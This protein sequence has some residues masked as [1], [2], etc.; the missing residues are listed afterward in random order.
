MDEPRRSGD[1]DDPSATRM[2]GIA[3]DVLRSF[4][5]GFGGRHLAIIGGLVPS[6]LVPQVP[7]GI[8]PHVGT[9]DLDLHLSLQLLAGETADYYGSIIDG[10]RSFGLRQDD[11][12][13]RRRLWRWIGPYR[14]IAL[15]VELLCPSTDRPAVPTTPT[16]G[17]AAELNIGPNGEITALAVGLGHL[18]VEDTEVV[19][20]RVET[21]AGSLTYP[22]PVTGLA[23]WLCLKSDAITLRDKPKD[24]YDIVWV[25]DALGPTVVAERVARSRLL[26]GDL[27]TEVT[28]ILARLVSDQFQDTMSVGPRAYADFFGSPDDIALMRH[29]Q[30]AIAELGRELRGS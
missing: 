2:L 13:E 12:G 23:S 21:R 25:I 11:K 18:V 30:S 16:S 17:T 27:A 28:A 5:S 6:L 14:D 29:A 22:F 8:D 7:V 10:L 9:A 20:R 3:A 26:S 4:G 24:A 15:R 19:E 1:Y